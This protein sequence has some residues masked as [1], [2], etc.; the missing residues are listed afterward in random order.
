MLVASQGRWNGKQVIG[1]DWLRGHGGGNGSLM[2]GDPKTL[3]SIGI[4]TAR[5]IDWPLPAEVFAG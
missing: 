1:Q 2:D 3:T 5:G 4:V